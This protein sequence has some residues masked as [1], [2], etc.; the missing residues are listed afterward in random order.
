MESIYLSPPSPI[1]DPDPQTQK[2]R[3]KCRV[4]PDVYCFQKVLRLSAS[5]YEVVVVLVYTYYQRR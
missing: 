1:P 3:K 5:Q 2:K 4:E